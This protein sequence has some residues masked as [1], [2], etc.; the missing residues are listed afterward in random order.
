MVQSE[1]DV[2]STHQYYQYDAEKTSNEFQ[3]V[4][5]GQN[6]C[7]IFRK[8]WVKAAVTLL[9]VMAFAGCLAVL[10]ALEANNPTTTTTSP[11]TG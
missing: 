3:R 11:A 2:T 9:L 7:C 8:T 10:V 6:K 5:G 1:D 4:F